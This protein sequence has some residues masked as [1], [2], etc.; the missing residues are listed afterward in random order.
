MLLEASSSNNK[1]NDGADVVLL[2]ARNVYES[3]IGCVRCT[4]VCV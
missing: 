4:C 1:N 3:R 2:D